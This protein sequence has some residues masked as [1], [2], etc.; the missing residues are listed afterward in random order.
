MNDGERQ[1]GAL[2]AGSAF[3]IWG[4]MP[5]YFKQVDFVPAQEIVAY[6]ILFAVGLLLIIHTV[7]GNWASV[8]A[9]FRARRNPA[10][11]TLS[12]V[13]IGVNWLFFTW[14]VTHERVLETSLGYFI[15]PLVSVMLGVVLLRER[16]RPAAVFAVA[17]ASAGMVYEVLTYGAVP[18]IA[19]ALAFSFALYGLV[20]KHIVIPSLDGLLFEMSFLVPIG[21][22][23][24]AY[25]LV[26]GK[27]H[28]VYDGP[29]VSGIMLLSAPLTVIPLSLFGAG[30][31]RIH[32]STLGF[33]QYIAPSLTFL[34]AV[35][36][37][38]EPFGLT[39]LV[40]FSC[41]WIAL[42]I[43]TFDAVHANRRIPAPQET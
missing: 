13:F 39:R 29:G 11:L 36:I 25:V 1:K 16:L 43:F 8:R 7:T 23:Y 4:F 28:F 9:S 32:L 18:W 21:G 37:Y 3:T 22:A 2:Y 30:A 19:L 34:A 27:G 6:R 15:N 38:H 14:A 26:S 40:T 20:R 24:A 31:K 35:L 5:I 33:L 10:L 41:I 12:A 17:L 42:V